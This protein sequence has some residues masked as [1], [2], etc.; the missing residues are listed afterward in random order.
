MWVFLDGDDEYMFGQSFPRVVILLI[1]LMLTDVSIFRWW[2]WVV[3]HDD[4]DDDSSNNLNDY[5][6]NDDNGD[7]VD[8]VNGDENGDDVD[9]DDGDNDEWD[10]Q[11]SDTWG[12]AESAN[13]L[14]NL[15]AP[16]EAEG[17]DDYHHPY[18]RIE[19]DDE[20]E[21]DD[22]HHPFAGDEDEDE[23]EE[24]DDTIVMIMCGWCIGW[25]LNCKISK[26]HS[27]FENLWSKKAARS[28]RGVVQ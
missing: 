1:M 26:E 17:E 7:D 22:Y 6:G 2:W 24:D 21:E 23:E 4:N 27:M 3:F 25:E 13:W 12:M 8:N 9:D 18:T 11:M 5:K 10:I 20:E 16:N 14:G 19:D 28:R 15:F